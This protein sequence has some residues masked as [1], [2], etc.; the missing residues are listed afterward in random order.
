M[1]DGPTL[2]SS[3]PPSAS[4]EFTHWTSHD[5]APNYNTDI[6]IILRRTLFDGE[7]VQVGHVVARPS[8]SDYGEIER[9]R[10]N[11]LVLPL[12]GVFAKHDG[13]RR[14]VIATPNHAV[15]IAAGSPYRISYPAGIGDQLMITHP[16]RPL[17]QGDQSYAASDEEV[18]R[19]AKELRQPL[20]LCLADGP[21][22][23]QH[24][25]GS[26]LVAQDRPDVL[27]LQPAFFH[28]RIQRLVG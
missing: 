15:F 13:P 11:V 14:Q 6:Q 3:G 16:G 21:P 2:H 26:S 28:R 23:T 10:S 25:R 18:D 17:C 7:L 5:D 1:R 9:Q 22:A 20:C 19:H 8:S 24:F 12:A 27:V 4:A